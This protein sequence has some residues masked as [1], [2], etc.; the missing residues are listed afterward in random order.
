MTR[1]QLQRLVDRHLAPAFPELTFRADGLYRWDGDPV[2]RGFAFDRSSSNRDGVRVHVLAQPLLIPDDVVTLGLAELLDDVFLRDGDEAELMAGVRA[3][4]EG[5]GRAFLRRTSTCEALAASILQL[6]R[7]DGMGEGLAHEW[8]G[9]C[10][11]WIGEDAGA[12]AALA[13]AAQENAAGTTAWEAEA[14]ERV[15]ELQ[16]ALATSPAATLELLAGRA[17]ATR[18]ALGLDDVG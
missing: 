14:L 1:K 6:R 17:R 15:R 10:L 12:E 3:K 5:A 11:A 8:R 16:A 13:R 18:A 4:A 2:L 7:E 9:A